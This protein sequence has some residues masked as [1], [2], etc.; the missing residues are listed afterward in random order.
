MDY[1]YYMFGVVGNSQ[2]ASDNLES[3]VVVND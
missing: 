1:E 2:K 3:E